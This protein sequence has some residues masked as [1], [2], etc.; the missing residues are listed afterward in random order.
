MRVAA[1]ASRWSFAS[2][3]A[4][5]F[6]VASH[7]LRP[8]VP[9]RLSELGASDVFIAFAVAVYP[10][11]SFWLAIPGGR[12][13]DRV[14]VRR[15]IDVSL[16]AMALVGV[17]FGVL[18]GRW[19]LAALMGLAGIVELGGWLA[20]QAMT[21]HAGAG[22]FRRKQLALFAFA[23]GL[24]MT[25]GPAIGG[26]L[27]ETWGFQSLG[28]A[29]ACLALACLVSSRIVPYRRA[30][31]TD[32]GPEP[33]PSMTFAVSRLWG[34]V[35]VRI[36]LTSSA[37][38]M[39]VIGIRNSFYPLMLERAGL[40]VGDIGILV[41]VVGA[42]SLLVRGATP[43]LSRLMS[44]GW[45]LVIGMWFGVVGMAV[46][47]WLDNI[48]AWGIA[49]VV[50]G[51]GLGV[52][53]PVTVEIMAVHT[54]VDERGLAMGLRLAVNRASQVAQSVQ[55]GLLAGPIGLAGSFLV[56]AVLLGGVSAWTTRDR[57]A[58]D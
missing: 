43:A 5:C 3:A 13:T 40:S 18:D 51:L 25:L 50:M 35:P 26:R 6:W 7:G 27:Y 53:P 54:P 45:I 20:L 10:I 16:V 8:L 4:L 42:A 24:G 31:A 2:L 21:S 57:G 58:V 48:W 11:A 47:P 38:T 32:R 33:P 56:S 30:P 41:G 37:V 44:T 39:Y 49:A 55:Y 14:G 19:A 12:L 1:L 29:Y 52:N 28:A 36:A 34:N 23:W 22:E 46:T 15:I 9:L 17:G